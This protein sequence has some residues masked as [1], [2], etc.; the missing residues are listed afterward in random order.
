MHVALTTWTDKR[1][2][3]HTA[4]Q[5]DA[6]LVLYFGGKSVLEN[7]ERYHELKAFYPQAHLLGC[8]T[9]GEIHNAEVLDGTIAAAA[10]HFAHTPLKTHAL[11]IAHSDDSFTAGKQLAEV[12]NQPDLRHIFL[13]SDGT[14]VNGSELVRGIYSVIAEDISVTGGLAGD[15]ADFKRTLVGLDAPP[16]EKQIAAVGFYGDAIR[17][18]YGSVGGWTAFGPERRITKSHGNILYELDGRPALDLYNQY[19][20]EDGAQLPKD[21]L[22]FPLSIRPDQHAEHEIVRTILAVDA[23]TKSLHYAGDVPEGYVAQLMRGDFNRLVDGAAKAALL[24]HKKGTPSSESLA[25]LVSCIGRK[26]LLGQSISDETEAVADVFEGAIPTVGFYS[27][28]EICHQQFTGKCGLHNQTMTVT[29]LHE[30]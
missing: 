22:Q 10:V 18:G 24:A 17:I 15:G 11:P 14:N 27:Y 23:E 21:A 20:G 13:L 1:G 12:L 19:L 25:L 4:P 5:P 16:A 7:A 26:L 30:D 3:Q 6:Q 2:W 8:S 9:G 28:G 29:V